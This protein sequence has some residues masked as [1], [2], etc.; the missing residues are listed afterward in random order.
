MLNASYNQ[1]HANFGH[2]ILSRMECI[3]DDIRENGMP[4]L[5]HLAQWLIH[6]GYLNREQIFAKAEYLCHPEEHKLFCT[7]FDALE[8]DDPKYHGWTREDDGSY[9]VYA[10]PWFNSE[11]AQLH[12]KT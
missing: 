3:R 5:I 10:Y 6:I 8:G 2:D 12:A 9:R 11:A 4:G 7:L 1:A